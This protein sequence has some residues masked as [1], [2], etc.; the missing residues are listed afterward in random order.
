MSTPIN[1][2][3]IQ[4]LLVTGNVDQFS[5][6]E[7]VAY[8]NKLC[9]SMGL[10]PL[11]KPFEFLRLSGRTVLYAGKGCAD[12]LRKIHG[13]SI[14][15]VKQEI[16]NDVLFVTVKGQDK[17]GRIDSEIGALPIGGLKGDAL[18]IAT[19][20]AL[21]KA[22]RRLTLSM[23]GLGI[24]DEMEVESIQQPHV[25]TPSISVLPPSEETFENI[26][27]LLKAKGKDEAGLLAYLNKQ[28]SS[29]IS[30]IE[31]MNSAHIDYAYRVL[32]GAK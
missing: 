13:V 12:Q 11:T 23:V 3:K 28:T 9:D 25:D 27:A 1:V 17:T 14:I 21:T 8:V 4:E 31:E 7:K 15:D 5:P 18:A 26:R 2:D 20:K 19:M 24:L 10:N 22:K 6:A 16:I 29:N 30:K 32:G